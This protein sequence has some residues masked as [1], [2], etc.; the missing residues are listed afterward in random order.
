MDYRE[1]RN[2][3]NLE[4]GASLIFTGKSYLEKLLGVFAGGL[5]VTDILTS[6]N[7]HG[8]N[9]HGTTTRQERNKI[10]IEIYQTGGW[11]YL[12]GKSQSRREIANVLNENGYKEGELMNGFITHEKLDY[13]CTFSA[14]LN[15]ISQLFDVI[16]KHTKTPPCI[17]G[18]VV[19]SVNNTGDWRMDCYVVVGS[20]EYLK[21]CSDVLM[22][23]DLFQH[24]DGKSILMFD[25][26]CSRISFQ[27]FCSLVGCRTYF[28]ECVKYKIPP[29]INKIIYPC[30]NGPKQVERRSKEM[31]LKLLEVIRV[32]FPNVLE[33]E[34]FKTNHN[35][36]AFSKLLLGDRGEVRREF[37]DWYNFRG[38]EEYSKLQTTLIDKIHGCENVKMISPCEGEDF[39]NN[40]I[41][42]GL[43][44]ILQLWSFKDQFEKNRAQKLCEEFYGRMEYIDKISSYCDSNKNIKVLV[45]LDLALEGGFHA[46]SLIFDNTNKTITRYEPNGGA[47]P[48][49]ENYCIDNNLRHFVSKFFPKYVYVPPYAFQEQ[50]GAQV[51]ENMK[52]SIFP[53]M[54][55]KFG[56]KERQLEEE[57]FCLAWSYLFL[58]FVKILPTFSLREISYSLESMKPNELAF[59]IRLYQAYLVKLAKVDGSFEIPNDLKRAR[60][61]ELEERTLELDDILYTKIPQKKHAVVKKINDEDDIEYHERVFESLDF[62]SDCVK[63]KQNKMYDEIHELKKSIKD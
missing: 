50:I 17:D 34:E 49:K 13:V 11:C 40:L 53:T 29:Y 16:A 52:R 3:K 61:E 42:V 27:T 48:T 18:L 5:L 10:Q 35:E 4:N 7:V 41:C 46:N 12:F 58:L 25:M 23:A 15:K 22:Y 60:L 51:N 59:L 43:P 36:E 55:T 14:Y 20:T 21:K 26:S 47:R 56:S 32:E 37:R 44:N 63:N 24:V 8:G 9:V 28:H 62:V 6:G 38:V 19:Y 45:P 39:T 54:K 2:Y 30:I 31:L 33:F 57:G 1:Y